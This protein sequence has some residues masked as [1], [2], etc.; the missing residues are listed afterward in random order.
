MAGRA[1]ATFYSHET[2][3]SRRAIV[4]HNKNSY[5]SAMRTLNDLRSVIAE[6]EPAI[7][8]EL[9]NGS[10]NPWLACFNTR[11]TT[12]RSTLELCYDIA[13]PEPIHNRIDQLRARKN[14]LQQAHGWNPPEDIRT[15][16][17]DEFRQLL[18]D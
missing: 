14:E 7:Q 11:L 18:Q 9:T 8:R 13:E 10:G 17:L 1:H 5:H 3:Y 12:F 4:R 2:S 15:S 6:V 16:L